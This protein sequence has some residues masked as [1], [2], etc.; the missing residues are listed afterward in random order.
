MIILIRR[1]DGTAGQKRAAYK[2][3]RAAVLR[4]IGAVDTQRPAVRVA[5]HLNNLFAILRL[6]YMHQIFSRIG[7]IDFRLHAAG[8]SDHGA[9]ALCDLIIIRLNADLT[10]RK[11][12]PE[13]RER[14]CLGM[15]TAQVHP[16][17]L[18]KL[19]FNIV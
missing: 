2:G 3:A 12:A 16:G 15:N 10:H 1:G 18:R 13:Q 8:L 5:E 11:A 17:Y 19:L 14:I 6:F 4:E 7:N 9:V